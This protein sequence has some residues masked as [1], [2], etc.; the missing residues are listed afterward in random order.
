I[1]SMSREIELQKELID[2]LQHDVDALKAKG[3]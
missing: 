1:Q 3:E 2:H